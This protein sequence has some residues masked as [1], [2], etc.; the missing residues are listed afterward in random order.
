MHSSLDVVGPLGM[1]F[2]F[3]GILVPSFC[4]WIICVWV[5]FCYN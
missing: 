4:L 3:G 5:I 1:F 2:L